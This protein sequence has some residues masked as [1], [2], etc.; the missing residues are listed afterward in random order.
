MYPDFLN[1]PGLENAARCYLARFPPDSNRPDPFIAD[2]LPRVLREPVV[3]LAD[4]LRPWVRWYTPLSRSSSPTPSKLRRQQWSTS[5]STTRDHPGS[6]IEWL[7]TATFETLRSH[8]PLYSPATNLAHP[9]VTSTLHALAGKTRLF[10][11]YGSAEWF[12]HPSSSFAQAARRAGVDV[13]V[14]PELGGF[15]IENCVLPA[16]LGGPS[17]RLVS[18]MRSWLEGSERY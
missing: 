17:G 10:V 8:H 7:D 4:A 14:C 12:A 16:E 15:H 18:N 2:P 1:R 6:P 13:T 9:F 11:S 3:A 5:V